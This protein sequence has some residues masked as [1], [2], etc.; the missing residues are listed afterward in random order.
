M[1]LVHYN[2][3]P[4][5]ALRVGLIQALGAMKHAFL[6][7]LL[8]LASGDCAAEPY[9][10]DSGTMCFAAIGDEA[11]GSIVR[12]VPSSPFSVSL[13]EQARIPILS[14]E[15]FN[16]GFSASKSTNVVIRQ[17]ARVVYSFR[18]SIYDYDTNNVCLM[19]SPRYKAWSLHPMPPGMGRCDCNL[20]KSAP[21]NSFKPNPLRRLAQVHRCSIATTHRSAGCGSA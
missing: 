4:T 16:V 1:Y 12:S 2:H 17:G 10:L 11:T 13:D 7:S 6:I 9:T 8:I 3:S 19:F 14:E 5:S 21:N 15:Q 20:R 18:L